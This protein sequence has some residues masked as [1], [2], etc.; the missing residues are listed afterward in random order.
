MSKRRF[1]AKKILKLLLHHCE[2]SK[3]KLLHQAFPSGKE[4][5]AVVGQQA[6]RMLFPP[7]NEDA[8]WSEGRTFWIFCSRMRFS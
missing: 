3:F 2:S 7:P 8:I 5:P 6:I 4:I 1:A